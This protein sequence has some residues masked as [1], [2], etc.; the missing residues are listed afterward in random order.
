V[1]A[2]LG[3]YRQILADPAARAFTLAGLVARLP[4]SMTGL[5]I[6]LLVSIT[7]GSFGRAGL[8]VAVVTVFGAAAAPWWGR[9][10]DRIGQAR[11]LVTATVINN[12]SLVLVIV[13]V[14][15]DWPLFS[16]LLAAAGVGLGFS[17]AGA[18]VRARWTHRLG[19]TPALNVAFAWEAVVDEVVFI[20]GPVLA[21]FLATSLH[22][23]LGVATGAVLG[24]LGSLAL[25]AQRS[26]EPPVLARTDRRAS[27][28]RL[29][30]RM[31]VPIVIA[32]AAL[33]AVFGGMEVVIVAFAEEAG[34][35]VLAGFLIMAWASGSLIAGLVT[36]AI[37]WRSSPLRRFRIGAAVLAASLLPL[38]FVSAPGLTAALL[39]LS[40]FSIA[41]TLI[42][43][44]AVTSNAVPVSRLNEALGW[45]ATGL[46]SGLALGAAVLGQ[47]IDVG[48]AHAG[49]WGVVVTGAL[50]VT[51]ALFV[52][53]PA[54]TGAPSPTAEPP[55]SPAATDRPE[56]VENP[57][58]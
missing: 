29:S 58:R 43:S 25:A 27:I 35:T 52:R 10:I 37:A 53:P 36:G 21:T 34:V 28:E 57:S 49:F 26:T 54:S 40:G 38:P 32:Y 24:L 22:P 50:L 33:G 51:A 44:V 13:S 19:G 17:S 12:V 18:S 7:T 55:G 2:G 5:G 45:T 31:M 39:L 9:I 20:V 42:A 23:A 14:L 16:T 56:P 3:A 6:V 30:V 4:L 15:Q 8:V 47:V 11:V 41:P 48:G 1:A 46:A